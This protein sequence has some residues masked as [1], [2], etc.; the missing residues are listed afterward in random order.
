M[1]FCGGLLVVLIIAPLRL[2][3]QKGHEFGI[4]SAATF[5]GFT[6]V[7]GGVHAAVRPGGR[8]RFALSVSAG[9][10]RDRFTVRG[11]VV[12]H[13]LLNPTSQ[14]REIYAGGGLAGVSGGLDEGYLLLVIG[15]ESK[16]GGRAGWMIET[17]IGG[18]VRVVVGYTWRSMKR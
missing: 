13:F 15:L 16:P 18:G 8:A 11:E 4:Q 12:G 5:A 6:F 1:R 10:I 7:G 17:G 2:S 14:R 9:A 3:A